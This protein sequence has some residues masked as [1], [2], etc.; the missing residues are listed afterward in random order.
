M[1][2]VVLMRRLLQ[3]ELLLDGRGLMRAVGLREVEGDCGMAVLQVGKMLVEDMLRSCV[4]DTAGSTSI[5]L[6]F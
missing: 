4:H 6:G 5:A 1:V 2:L 3:L